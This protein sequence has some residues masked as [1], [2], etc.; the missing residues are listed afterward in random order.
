MIKIITN[1]QQDV[2]QPL[3]LTPSQLGVELGLL[4]GD[5]DDIEQALSVKRQ[6]SPEI[7]IDGLIVWSSL[8]VKG[9]QA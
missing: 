7:R 4:E 5:G 2:H 3:L 9:R 8:G 1:F 6:Q